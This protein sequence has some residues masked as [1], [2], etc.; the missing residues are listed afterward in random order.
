[1][2]GNLV[3]SSLLFLFLSLQSGFAQNNQNSFAITPIQG[4][5]IFSPDNNQLKGN[6]Y[7]AE[8]AYQLNMSNN[9]ED[10][11]HLLRVKDIAIVF[12]YLNLNNVSIIAKPG[13]QGFLG[14][15]YGIVTCLDI[16]VFKT[17]KTE[18]I[19]SPGM[20]FVYASQTF[21]T[22][23]NPV[24]GSHINLAV[25]AGLKLQTSVSASTKIQAGINYFHYSNS[26]F[27]LPNDGI[28]SYNLAIGIVRD[29]NDPGP[30]RQKE[31]FSVDKKH[32]FEFGVGIGRRGFIQTGEYINTQTG[33]PINLTDSAA[34]KTAASNLYLAGFYAGYNYRLNQLLSLKIGTD[35]I[36]Y[37]KPFS[38][39]NF[40]RTFQELGTSYDK[41][42]L[43]LSLGTDIWLGRIALTANYGYYLHYNALNPV[44]FYWTLGAKYYIRPWMALDAK[45]FIHR[46]EAHY[47][48]FGLLFTVH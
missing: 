31:T 28:N 19:F 40:Y 26:A 17:G 41:L 9:K 43:G 30:S 24:I 2:N 29:I 42:S 8:L 6:F 35:I 16:S 38:W 46:F 3:L 25:Q 27:R 22:T 34:Q 12:S 21:Y 39:G 48:N 7:G 10:W 5:S 18:F 11:V 36:Y 45:I 15:N 33:K 47:A 37:F 44:N 13:S 32:S 23:Y 20:G 14:N 1:M 4:L